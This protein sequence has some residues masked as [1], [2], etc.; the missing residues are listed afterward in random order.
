[1][2]QRPLVRDRGRILDDQRAGRERG[3]N[4]D[5]AKRTAGNDARSGRRRPDRRQMRLAG[6]LRPDQR[7]G[8]RRPIRPGVDQ[9]QRALIGRSRQEILAREAFGVIERERELPRRKRRSA[10]D[11]RLPV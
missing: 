6:S 10:Y 3:G 8:A 4:V 2:E 11:G 7:D 5:F 1:M 9:R